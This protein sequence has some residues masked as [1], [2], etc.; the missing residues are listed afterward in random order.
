[1]DLVFKDLIK[2][3]DDDSQLDEEAMEAKI[4]GQRSKYAKEQ[5][6]L[7]IKGEIKAPSKKNVLSASPKKKLGSIIEIKNK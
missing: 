4:A 2:P 3:G 5:Y 6:R 7:K 1:M